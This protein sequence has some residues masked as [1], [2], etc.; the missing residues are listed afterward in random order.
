MGQLTRAQIVSA[1]L[2]KAGD[3]SLTTLANTWFNAWLRSQYRAWPWPFLHRRSSAISLAAGT[4]S[5]SV[6]AGSNGVTLEIQRILDPIRVG[7]STYSTKK[8]ARIVALVNGP[9]D[10]D[11]NLNDPALTRGLPD[12]FKIRADSSLWGKW[13]LI[14]YPVPDK[15]YRI[16]LDYLEQPADIS[17]DA[18]VPLYPNDRTMIQAV[19]VDALQYMD[20]GN[21]YQAELEILGSMVVD[22][23]AKYGEVMG[24][25]DQMGLDPGVFR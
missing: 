12:R 15:A 24:T 20:E 9:Q 17:A 3:T 19:L 22:D 21:R 18:T 2:N 1:G 10:Y 25:N 8:D 23:R 6:G 4:T 14:P 5:L 13:T 11:E 7:D 16:Y